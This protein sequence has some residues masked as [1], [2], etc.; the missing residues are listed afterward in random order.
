MTY[1]FLHTY[2]LYNVSD[3]S[4]LNYKFDFLVSLTGDE[5][6]WPYQSA[7]EAAKAMGA[8]IEKRVNN[9][10]YTLLHGL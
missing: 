4:K 8:N 2:V 5:K 3:N 6:L 7:I 1:V 9:F 10:L